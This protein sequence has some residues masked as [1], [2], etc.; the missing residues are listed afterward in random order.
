M[1]ATWDSMESGD[2]LYNDPERAGQCHEPMNVS[3]LKFFAILHQKLRSLDMCLKLLCHFVSGKTYTRS[4]TSPN[5]KLAV[6]AA[7]KE[8]IDHIR[9][10]CGFLI[11]YSTKIGGNTNTGPIADRFFY[12]KNRELICSV[13]RKS[14]G[15]EAFVKLLSYFNMILSITQQSDASKIVKPESVKELGYALMIHIKRASLLP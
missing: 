13:I 9:K 1:K 5:V 2:M 3:D 8:V 6:G 14:S 4:E 10:N 7:K 11:D 12:P 15:R